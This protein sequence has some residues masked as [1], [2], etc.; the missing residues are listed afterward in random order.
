MVRRRIC[1]WWLGEVV[2]SRQYLHNRAGGGCSSVSIAT[3]IE[4]EEILLADWNV[5]DFQG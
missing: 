4:L 1:G 2:E 5:S 3:V